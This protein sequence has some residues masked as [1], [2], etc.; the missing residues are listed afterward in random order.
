M[1]GRLFNEDIGARF[2]PRPAGASS[3]DIMTIGQGG[4]QFAAVP[5]PQRGRNESGPDQVRAA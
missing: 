2:A 5:A 1:R 3:K 4:K